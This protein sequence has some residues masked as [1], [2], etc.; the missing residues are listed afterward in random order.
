[1]RNTRDH[2]EIDELKVVLEISEKGT[3][4]TKDETGNTKA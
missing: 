1:M 4:E 2:A 3:E